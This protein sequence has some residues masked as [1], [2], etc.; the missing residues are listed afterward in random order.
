M[1]SELEFKKNFT[2]KQTKLNKQ[3]DADLD[4]MPAK[5]VLADF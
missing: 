4:I 3:N 5:I 2:T 1:A